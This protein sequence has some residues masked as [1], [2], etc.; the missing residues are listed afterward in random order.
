MRTAV[1][2]LVRVGP[3][4]PPEAVA[5]ICGQS[6]R[7]CRATARVA[8]QLFR[9]ALYWPDDDRVPPLSAD[10]LVDVARLA[11]PDTVTALVR[12][13]SEGTMDLISAHTEHGELFA[14]AAVAAA[15][16]LSWAWDDCAT[17]A[18]TVNDT[19]LAFAPHFTGTYWEAVEIPV[20]AV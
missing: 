17:V 1:I 9:V 18:V 5:R 12:S 4:P 11:S 6:V 16:R 13:S 10:C 2:E 8:E 3:F 20:A 7:V 19:P 14:L 15:A